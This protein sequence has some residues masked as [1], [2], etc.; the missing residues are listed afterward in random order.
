VFR[1][2]KSRKAPN[3]PVDPRNPQSYILPE[4][5]NYPHFRL[6]SSPKNSS[7]S[8]PGETTQGVP[9][10]MLKEGNNFEGDHEQLS[11]MFHTLMPFKVREILLVSSLYDAFVI[12][13]EGLI[14][15]L[16]IG[17][18]QHLL[19]SSPPRVT[20]TNSGIKAMS[21]L[22]EG[23][24][25]L[26]I[27]MSK[28][29]GMDPYDFGMN[30]K[31]QHPG[32]PV[33]LL[34]T[35]SSDVHLIAQKK[36]KTGIDKAFY[37]TGD[38]TLFL[39]IIKYVEDA[40]NAHDDTINGNVRVIIMVEDSIR[41]YSTLLPIF[42]TEI[43]RQTQ[44]AISEDLNEMQRLI[45]RRARLKILLA[46][47]FEEGM[48]YFNKYKDYV[49]GIVTDIRYPRNGKEDPEAGYALSREV[50]KVSKFIPILMQS[51]EKVNRVKSL[52][53]GTSFLNKNSPSLLQD[54]QHFLLNY[55]GF[56]DFIFLRPKKRRAKIK[57]GHL[58]GDIPEEMV[59][60]TRA[61]NMHEFVRKLQEVPLESIQFHSERNH[62]S[63]WLFARCEF[64]PAMR[65][66]PKKASDFTDLNEVRKY[67]LDTFN[68]SRRHKQRAVITD[69]AQ[70]KYEFDSSF[71]RLTGDSLGGKGSGIAFMRS[72][73]TRYNFEKKYR[74]INI[75]VPS[76]VVLGTLEFDRFISE[77]NLIN[78]LDK[79]QRDDHEIAQAFL[80]SRINKELRDKLSLL[81]DH[82]KS[83]LAIRSSG[84]LEDS[85][86]FPFAGVYSTYM[87]PNNHNNKKT[88]LK[89]LCQAI[90]LVYASV[91]YK[92][93]MSYIESTS[94]KIEDEKMAVVIQRVVG[95]D[96]NGRFYPTFS[97]VVQSYNFYPVSHQI[98][99]DGIASIAVGLGKPIVTGEKALRFSPRYP[100]IIP[101]FSSTELTLKNSQRKLYAVDMSQKEFTLSE[102]EDITLRKLD[103][104]DIRDDGSLDLIASTY[105]M[106]DEI[107]R[108]GVSSDGTLVVT[109]SGILKYGSLPLS[110][111]LQD[112]VDIGKRG[113]GCPIEI[114]FAVDLHQEENVPP[115]MSILQ[116]RPLVP[117]YD[118][119]NISLD[120]I[121][122]KENLLIISKRALGNGVNNSI[123]D[124]VFVRPETFD[125][126]KTIEIADE[127]GVINEKL[128]TSSSPYILM[129][130]GRWG[131]QDRWLGIPVRWHQ[132][133]GVKIIVETALENFDIDPSQGTHFF[134]NVVS[135]GIG[136]IHT[137]SQS[138]TS[139]IDW[140]WINDQE[141]KND[142]QYVRHVQ[143]SS[144]VTVK[145]DGRC[146]HALV[147]KPQP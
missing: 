83:P 9:V 133:Y 109:F 137:D 23:Q 79:S 139:F 73:L 132:I 105:N 76:T 97:G 101:E 86:D 20:R 68:E 22:K 104:T 71:T 115:V 45:T 62:F 146:G 90:K 77:N 75:G 129:G 34:A 134:Q 140:S 89:Q 35:N 131:T 44:R 145:I 61:S 65:M 85:Q 43:V 3:C 81:L 84:I 25:D 52:S 107:I 128:T 95:H 57:D 130:P 99:E 36:D 37:W 53:P 144:P 47:T 108:D 55:L 100:D 138:L 48:D 11:K 143:L 15:E 67:L 121:D 4:C 118:L 125:S 29:I 17:E 91:F 5:S 8:W 46:E 32:L 88:R 111:I 21:R 74:G 12:E 30:I 135:R 40:V 66:Q 28:N 16:I 19:L 120:R 94:L 10:S 126:S 26:V 14:S 58:P 56:G 80:G 124:I 51:S 39:A 72:L 78:F 33:I 92:E 119:C 96:H 87:L 60:I 24:Y 114:E 7:G 64:S 41:F 6:V 117:S 127:V 42:Y 103:I 1:T 82:F 122:N 18:Y 98:P 70:Q 27:T 142:L 63:N 49:L 147:E 31:D 110:S 38:S 112:L 54:L 106:N 93:A 50:R 113:M 69:F 123:R 13:E 116:I 141:V 136:Y 59:E 2:K 102:S